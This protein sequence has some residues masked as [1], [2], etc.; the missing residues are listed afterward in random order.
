M[1]ET[2]KLFKGLL[3]EVKKSKKPSSIL[4]KETIVGYWR[5]ANKQMGYRAESPTHYS[6]W[7][8]GGNQNKIYLALTA[9]CPERQQIA[10]ANCIVFRGSSNLQ[11]IRRRLNGQF[12]N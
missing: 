3:I 2:I 1:I 7:G 12:R 8:K 10:T 4:L 5:M 9:D 6:A 11:P